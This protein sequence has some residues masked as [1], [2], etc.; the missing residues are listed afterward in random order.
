MFYFV[1]LLSI[2]L[3]FKV[4]L[5]VSADTLIT[6]SFATSSFSSLTLTIPREFNGWMEQGMLTNPMNQRQCG[7]CWSFAINSALADRYNIRSGGRMGLWLSP[8]WLIS[9]DVT[10]YNHGCRGS[11]GLEQAALDLSDH[12]LGTY[13]YSDYPFDSY[14]QQTKWNETCLDDIGEISAHMC[15][16]APT[17]PCRERC[18][19]NVSLRFR[20]GNIYHIPDTTVKNVTFALIKQAILKSGPVLTSY[21]VAEDFG[22][23]T[24]FK[25]GGIYQWNGSDIVSGHAVVIVG[26]GVFRDREYWII[27]N[28]WGVKW[29]NHGYFYAYTQ[30]TSAVNFNNAVINID[31]VDNINRIKLPAQSFEQRMTGLPIRSLTKPS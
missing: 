18:I 7:G 9:C 31:A 12:H 27:K 26:W 25:S 4:P 13:L 15:H 22:D 20:A 14:Y 2:I 30:H 10:R 11:Y 1:S 19:S 29:G 28:S 16:Y 3:H 17:A 23:T 6:S 21:R 24:F 5:Q 8:Q